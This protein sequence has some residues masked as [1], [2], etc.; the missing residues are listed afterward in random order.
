MA[1]SR[2]NLFEGE[3]HVFGVQWREFLMRRQ[4]SQFGFYLEGKGEPLKILV[5]TSD[6]SFSKTARKRIDP[7]RRHI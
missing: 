4:R 1:H 6:L 2:T 5:M 7:V 3:T